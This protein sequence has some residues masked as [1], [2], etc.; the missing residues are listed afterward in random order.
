M[1]VGARD[2]DPASF[3]RLAQGFERG[4]VE[5]REFVEEQ[6]ALM[7]E[8]NLARAGSQPATHQRRQ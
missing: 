3:E 1:A 6:D 7:R 5:L 4:A 2:A 8:R